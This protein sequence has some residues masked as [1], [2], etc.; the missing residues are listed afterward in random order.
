MSS[1]TPVHHREVFEVTPPTITWKMFEYQ[2]P[3][4]ADDTEAEQLPDIHDREAWQLLYHTVGIIN[5]A[6]MTITF[7][8]EPLYEDKS[9]DEQ[10][11]VETIVQEI[12]RELLMYDI[13]WSRFEY[14][15]NR[16]QEWGRPFPEYGDEHYT[17]PED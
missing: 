6:T 2:G 1:G 4:P 12:R 3:V 15:K 9:G 16:Y 13:D 14:Y 8:D 7:P 10:F 17:D 5:E 11:V